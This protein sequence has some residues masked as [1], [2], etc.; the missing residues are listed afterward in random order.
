MLEGLSGYGQRKPQPSREPGLLAALRDG[1][2]AIVPLPFIKTTPKV[3]N[4]PPQEHP[5]AEE[6]Y[7]G[8]MAAND[9]S[10]LGLGSAPPEKPQ[11]IAMETRAEPFI[12]NSPG[13]PYEVP[14]LQYPELDIRPYIRKYPFR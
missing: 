8:P 4:F 5:Y 13:E 6:S 10:V 9:T 2:N 11:P 3:P 7:D 14:R 12:V 1:E